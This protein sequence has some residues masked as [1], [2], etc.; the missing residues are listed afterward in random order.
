MLKDFPMPS[1]IKPEYEPGSFKGFTDTRG[2]VILV[3]IWEIELCRGS[4]N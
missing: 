3:P 1:D 2:K 4:Q